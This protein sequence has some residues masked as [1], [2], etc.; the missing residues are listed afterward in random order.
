MEWKNVKI[1]VRLVIP[2]LVKSSCV[3]QQVKEKKNLTA[4]LL[5]QPP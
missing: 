5:D 4:I 2:L 3:T 1:T